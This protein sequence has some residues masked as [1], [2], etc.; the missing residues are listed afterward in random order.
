[1][2]VVEIVSVRAERVQDITPNDCRAEGMTA[3][4]NDIGVRYAFGQLWNSINE[5]RGYGWYVNPWVW[6][7]GFKRITNLP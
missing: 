5:K 4:N 3:K 2:P 7:I 6:V 1:M